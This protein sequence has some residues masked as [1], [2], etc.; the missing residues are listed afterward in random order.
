MSVDLGRRPLDV[1][2]EPEADALRLKS[3]QVR[4]LFDLAFPPLLGTLAVSLV[5]TALLWNQVP[6]RLLLA[7]VGTMAVVIVPRLAQVRAFRRKSRE[8][9][10]LTVWYRWYLAGTAASGLVFGALAVLFVPS[11]SMSL[12]FV[13]VVAISGLSCGAIA[14]YFPIRGAF[15]A[16]MIPA[17]LQLA[18]CFF[19]QGDRP[20]Q[21]VGILV[22][23]LMGALAQTGGRMCLANA[24]N[25]KTGLENEALIGALR[26]SEQGFRALSD[27]A[28]EGILLSENGICIG[29]NPAAERMCRY[30]ADEVKGRAGTDFVTPECREITKKKM[31]S[32]DEGPY[33]VTALRK[34]GTTF[35]CQIQ[36]KMVPYRGRLVR[37]SALRDITEDKR[38]TELLATERRRLAYILEGTNVGTWEWN[39]QTGEVVFNERWA[40]IIG[41]TLE[42]IS[43]TSIDT[44]TK[45]A[46]PDDLEVSGELLER[47]FGG[48]LDYYECE[49]RMRH[50]DG[51]WIW[52]LDRGRVAT[53]TADGKPF[54]MSGTHK[55]ISEQKRVEQERERL[56]AELK[57][58]QESLQFE[59]THDGL[60]LLWNR[61]AILDTLES[62]L[63]RSRRE[64]TPLGVV[65]A[66]IDHFKKINDQHGH[67]AGDAV[68]SEISQRIVAETRPYDAV[69]RYGG[70]EFV[71]VLPGCDPETTGQK[72]ERLR[73]S[74][75][76]TPI[77][78][79]EGVFK[80][81]M[82]FGVA[83]IEGHDGR[84]VDSI[85]RMADDALYRA[86]HAGRNCVKT[87]PSVPTDNQLIR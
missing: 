47:H 28:F 63:A 58:A 21:V 50:K 20:D 75:A 1:G 39:V 69:G 79:P 27:A 78:T 74:I 49:A 10:D 83:A 7:W 48:E 43:P 4:Q 82:S 53:W 64:L 41:Y 29:V 5:L 30:S 56:I 23:L 17:M 46:H 32:G 16:Y 52:V 15:L 85:I 11:G 33:E 61:S 60:T 68:L 34:D 86:K 55:E 44:W 2:P 51:S 80:V 14:T 3:M 54:L 71:I 8:G 19:F 24:R 84:D 38:A 13:I 77:R 6:N 26:D 57:K 37:V 42:E 72:A 66:D 59:A 67:L 12:D 18:G 40:N 45:F 62:E 31:L 25:L 22:L 36:A 81:T 76:E 65:I 73:V 70:E 9:E 35:D 87:G